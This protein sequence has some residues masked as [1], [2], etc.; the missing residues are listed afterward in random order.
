MVCQYFNL[1]TCMHS[2]TR[3]TKGTLYRHICAYCH[4][5]Y[6]KALLHMESECRNKNKLSKMT[7][8]GTG[9]A[10][11]K[12]LC[13]QKFSTGI[14]VATKLCYQKTSC[15]WF[16]RSN[17]FQTIRDGLTYAQAVKNNN[18]HIVAQH[19]DTPQN[20]CIVTRDSKNANATFVTSSKICITG[21]KC[22]SP[23]PTSTIPKVKMGSNQKL[24]LNLNVFLWV[25]DLH[26][27][28]KFH[29]L[30]LI[31]QTM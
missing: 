14:F 25:T 13:I 9:R 17:A 3:D 4:S 16:Y 12:S 6:G 2:S 19:L 20:A 8:V 21:G 7:I 5:K 29:K 27:W 15:S 23:R 28:M 24:L 11:P 30:M 31:C 10:I 18:T 1:G 26:F 22:H